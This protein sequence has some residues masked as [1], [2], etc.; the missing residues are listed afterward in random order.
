MKYLIIIGLVLLGFN[1]QAQSLYSELEKVS[2]F[3]QI[4]YPYEVHKQMLSNSIEVAYMDEGKANQTI[5]SWLRKL[6]ACMEKNY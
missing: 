5:Y 3:D 4:E 6:C 2:S 1:N